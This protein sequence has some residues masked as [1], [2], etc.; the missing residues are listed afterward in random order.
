[1]LKKVLGFG[2]CAVVLW[3]F[4]VQAQGEKPTSAG[5]GKCDL[6]V[7]AKAQKCDK[8]VKILETS[9]LREGVCGKCG[10]APKSVDVCVKK[11]WTCTKCNAWSKTAGNCGACKIALVEK[12]VKSEVLFQCPACGAQ[13]ATSGNCA[14]CKKALQ[15]TCKDSG[16]KPHAI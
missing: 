2:L 6:K 3:A 11:G 5:D 14:K 8:C 13:Q 1:M 7:I 9:D 10:T 16:K 15:K 4:A 12:T